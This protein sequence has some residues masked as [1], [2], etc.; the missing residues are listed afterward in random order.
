MENDSEHKPHNAID[1]QETGNRYYL[2]PLTGER[3]LSATTA[4]SIITKP[5]LPYW[6]GQQSAIRAVENLDRLNQAT[7]VKLCAKATVDTASPASWRRSAVPEP[8]S[9][10]PRQVEE[11]DSTG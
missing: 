1:D 8:M 2:H 11:H 5:A 7:R 9:A 4:L 6:Y 10:T 3:F